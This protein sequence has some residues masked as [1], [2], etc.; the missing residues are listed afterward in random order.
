VTSMFLENGL[1]AASREITM[2]TLEP[3]TTNMVKKTLVRNLCAGLMF[4]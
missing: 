1:Q 3:T 4:R 2:P